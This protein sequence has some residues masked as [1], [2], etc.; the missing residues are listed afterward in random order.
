MYAIVTVDVV[1]FDFAKAFDTVTHKKILYKLHAHGFGDKLV[2]L[3]SSFL[4]GRSQRVLLPNGFSSWK[5][6]G[7]GVPQGN[8]HGPLL[9]LLYV[10]DITDM[11]LPITLL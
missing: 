11:F 4:V 7:S 2:Y 8:I 3:I 10:N 6:V 9:F 1:Y 5:P